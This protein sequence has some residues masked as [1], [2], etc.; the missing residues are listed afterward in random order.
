MDNNG[1]HGRAENWNI[2]NIP[3]CLQFKWTR[4][5]ATTAVSVQLDGTKTDWNKKNSTRRKKN[6]ISL[7]TPYLWTSE[8]VIVM[9]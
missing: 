2:L 4:A 9:I 3:A 6:I 7:T 8:L 1:V 5:Y